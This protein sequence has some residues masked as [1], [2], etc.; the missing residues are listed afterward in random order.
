MNEK[1]KAFIQKMN[2]NG[3]PLPILRDANG[4][5]SYTLTMYVIS[6]T[7][8]AIALIGKLAGFLGGVNF[9]ECL[10]LY[11]ACSGAYLGRKWQKGSETLEPSSD[12]KDDS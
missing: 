4:K 12:K 9:S 2:E 3:V 7:L 5:G 1:L 6:F 10:S 8:C 11:M